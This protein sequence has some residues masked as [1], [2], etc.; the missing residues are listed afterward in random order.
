MGVA[1]RGWTIG[2]WALPPV[3]SDEGV[4]WLA[5]L[6]RLR[7]IAM[8]AQAIT[9]A[10]TW[11]VI[12]QPTWTIPLLASVIT[13][14]GLANLLTLRR[15]DSPRP[16]PRVGLLAH[17]SL[18]VIAL[19]AFFLLAG[20]HR[21]PFTVLY[22]IHVSMAAVMLPP[23]LAAALTALVVATFAST[24]LWN[25][26]LRLD[27]HA[28]PRATLETLGSL[29]SF[30]IAVASV[31]AFVFGLARSLRDQ[32]HL[33]L[34]AQERTARIDRLRAVGTLAAGAAH[35]LNTPLATMGLRV[36]RIARRYTDEATTDD[37]AVIRAQLDRCTSVVERL[38]YGAGDPSASG[39]VRAPM[40]QLVGEAIRLWGRDAS[41]AVQV[42]DHSA[43]IEIEVPP[44]AFGQALINLIENAREAQ[45]AVGVSTALQIGLSR[46]G[47]TAT[48][49][50]RDRGCGLPDKADQ[51]GDPFFTTK[52]SGTGLG[53][54][55]AR[56]V[57][58]G[59]GGGLGYTA[60]SD[61]PGTI[62]RWWFPEAT[63]RTT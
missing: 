6:V 18:D 55:V 22:V 14:L 12:D 35:E 26:P 9:L 13:G 16:F 32:R 33:V 47:D 23:R 15:R 59:A 49:E 31:A 57:A 62:A 2:S 20:G 8:V 7:W 25:L 48:I 42:D 17:L 34:A 10:F 54:F 44:I 29:A 30:T 52:E 50:V 39:L 60:R 36:R 40:A 58:D 56:A 19:T 24:H 41:L 5:W 37:L 11:P 53:V 27:G 43:G 61:G 46:E 21:N 45:E 51:V 63:R 1:V 3:Q 38:L 28:I 4:I